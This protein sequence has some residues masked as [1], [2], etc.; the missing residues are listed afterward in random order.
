MGTYIAKEK[1]IVRKWHVVSA[2]GIPLGRLAVR[3]TNPGGTVIST[4]ALLRRRDLAEVIGSALAAKASGVGHQ[5]AASMLGLR[6]SN[7][8]LAN[9][10]GP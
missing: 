10:A 2:E 7:E 6:A 9:P 4:D 5:R 8:K 1:D 3:V